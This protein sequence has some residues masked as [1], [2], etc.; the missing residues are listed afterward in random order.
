MV[1]HDGHM[2]TVSSGKSRLEQSYLVSTVYVRPLDRVDSIDQRVQNLKA[3]GDGLPA[4][5]SN[6]AVNQFLID[7]DAGHNIGVINVLAQVPGQKFA[8]RVGE[9]HQVQGNIGVNQDH[10]PL[11]S[12]SASLRW[13]PWD[14]DTPEPWRWRQA[15]TKSWVQVL[16]RGTVVW[17]QVRKR[18]PSSDP[19]NWNF[20]GCQATIMAD[21]SQALRLG[22][23]DQ[24]AIE[25]V[26]VVRRQAGNPFGVAKRDR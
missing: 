11:R 15:W 19:E 7:L 5:N 22:L 26:A 16:S 17:F 1:L 6:L 21:Q 13:N 8:I 14:D 4:V 24:H 18:S 2:Q 12:A 3:V 23:G 20:V 9:T 25:G 10:G